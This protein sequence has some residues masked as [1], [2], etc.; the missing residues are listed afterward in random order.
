MLR[1]DGIPLYYQIET[2]LRKK[3]LSGELPPLSLLPSEEALAEDRPALI[4]VPMSDRQE[5]LIDS[6]GWLRTELL[7]T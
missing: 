1:A 3:I 6:I 7:R 2:I 5:E 4:E